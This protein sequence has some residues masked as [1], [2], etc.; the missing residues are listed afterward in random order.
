MIQFQSLQHTDPEIIRHCFNDCFKDYFVP[1][2]LSSEQFQNKLLTEAIDLSLSFGAFENGALQG[3][4]LHGIDTIDN[5]R[6]AYN[7]GTGLLPSARGKSLSL[8]LYEYSIDQLRKAGIEKT[9]LEVFQQN[10]AAIN[11]YQRAGFNISRVINSYKGKPIH[12]QHNDYLVKQENFPDWSWI[13]ANSAWQPAWQYNPHSLHRGWHQYR[14]FAAYE[15]D[16]P[17]AFIIFNQSSGRV[18]L[19]GAADF[20]ASSGH[21]EALFT[22]AAGLY[23]QELS[24]AHVASVEAENFLQSIGLQLFIYSYE[25]ERTL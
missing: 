24:V 11:I 19:F 10:K 22:H 9:M 5:T 8:S 12:Q 18:A 1:F 25:M 17:V 16:E 21:L 4:I 14:L 13:N 23:Q 3:L 6:V 2:Q 7:A 20:P 15:K